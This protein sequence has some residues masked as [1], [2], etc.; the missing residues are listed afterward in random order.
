MNGQVRSTL[1]QVAELAG[2]SIASVSR[3]LNGQAASVDMI[4][5][6]NDAVARLGYVPDATA[7]SLKVG[8]TEQLALVVADVG[9]P[10][11]VT[12]MHAVANTVRASGY[13]LVL[14]TYRSDPADILDV[15]RSFSRGYADGLVISPLRVTKD[16]TEE[17]TRLA[18]PTVVIGTVPESLAVDNVRAD[19]ARGVRL[20]VDHL[21]EQGRR[22]IG[23]INGPAGTVPAIARQRGFER[24]ARRHAL[25]AER[26]PI[27]AADEFT[28]AAGR[29]AARTLLAGHRPEALIC[30]NDLLAVGAMHELAKAG[31]RVPDDVAVAGVDDTDLASMTFPGLTSVSLGSAERGSMAATLLLERIKDPARPPRRVKVHPYLVVRGSTAAAHASAVK[32]PGMIPAAAEEAS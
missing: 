1:G 18:L 24:G 6:V 8:R 19:S 2:V 3:V 28:F 4:E 31:L 20:L 12:M 14:S 27:V 22:A 25:E 7:R 11:Y 30:A 15:L 32:A 17:I 13:R 21:V 26:C 5:R 9:N 23:F 16:L 10:A 29:D